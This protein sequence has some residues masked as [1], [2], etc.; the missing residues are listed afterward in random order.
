MNKDFYL[1]FENK[2]R[3][4]KALIKSRQEKYLSFITPF[5]EIKKNIRALDI[6]CGRGEWLEILSEN[7]FNAYGVDT[8]EGMVEYSKNKGFKIKAKDGISELKSLKDNSLEIITAFQVVEHMDFNDVIELCVQ[9]ERVLTPNGILILE[10]PNPDNL[11]V[12]THWFHLDM[13]HKKPI[14]PTLLEYL[15]TYLGFERNF[16]HLTGGREIEFD[17]EPMSIF[18][19]LE[20]SSPDYAVIA[21]KEGNK[22]ELFND[23]FNIKTGYNLHEMAIRYDNS[24]KNF[25]NKKCEN[26]ERELTHTR[27]EYDKVVNSRSWKITK[28]LRAVAHL[29]RIVKSKLKP[30][31]C[32]ITPVENFLLNDQ[33][34]EIYRKLGG[35]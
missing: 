2:F 23:A 15:T 33:E 8:D 26:L 30:T 16:L 35:R 5:K 13:T 18:D 3:G 29:L 4:S 21:Q 9:A 24:I 20:N 10:T 32:C 14:P 22:I 34:L 6:G 11:V 31:K 19:V 12:G 17:K 28:P 27:S 7:G 1:S 25:F